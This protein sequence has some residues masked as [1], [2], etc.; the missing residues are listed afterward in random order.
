MGFPICLVDRV[1]ANLY[2]HI[3]TLAVPLFI[4]YV[5]FRL[6]RAWHKNQLVFIIGLIIIIALCAMAMAICEGLAQISVLPF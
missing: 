6:Y 3:L 2:G 4:L 1:A 5:S